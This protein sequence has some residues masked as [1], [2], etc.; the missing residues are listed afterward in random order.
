MARRLFE[1]QAHGQTF[2]GVT[3]HAVVAA[4]RMELGWDLP[5][6]EI[7]DDVLTTWR[8]T[9]QRGADERASWAQRR[10]GWWPPTWPTCARIA[11][12]GPAKR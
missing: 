3:P 7:P 11:A 4:A 6:F 1:A 12:S 9:G 8:A 10:S 5:A 2:Y